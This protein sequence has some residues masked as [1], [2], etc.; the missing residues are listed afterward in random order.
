MALPRRARRSPRSARSRCAAAR[1]SASSRPWSTPT[2]P[3]RRSSPC[4]P[5]S[6][7][8]WS[9]TSPASPR[10]CPAS[11]SSPAAP[12]WWRTTHRSTPAS[13]STTAAS[14]GIPWPRFEVLDTAVLARRTLLRDE[15]PNCRLAT[16]ARVFHATT[17]PNHRALSD[18]RA[19]VDVLH[20][21]FERLGPLGVTSLEEVSTFTARVTPAQ[22]KKRHLAEHLPQ[23]P[24]VY[25]FRDARD[26]VLYVGTSRNLRARVRTYFTESE[27]RT[28]MGEM[29]MLAQRV[30]GI[31][32]ASTLEAAGPRA[33][34]HRPAPPA[35][36]PALQVP[37]PA[38]LAQ[39]HPR[40]V[41]PAVGRQAHP[42]RRRRLHRPVRQPVVRRRR[43]GRPARRVP[44][45]PVHHQ[46]RQAV[47]RV[48][49]AP[50]PS[51]AT[52]SRRATARSSRTP[53]RPRCTACS[54][55]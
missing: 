37:R 42:R 26:D 12:S 40:A 6:P 10:C 27:T 31:V 36:Q 55:P 24:G 32:C 23:A 5:A 1:C 7:T 28:R 9:S 51:W 39:A 45:P 54:A 16:L 47:P 43:H 19:T 3:S 22:R 50:S 21:L 17:T 44:H 46:A 25:L 30:E 13:S 18:A 14:S 29:V 34:P 20:G 11:W 33:P 49:P 53:T 48:R 8:P 35:V 15:V 41:A 52:A 4:S 2:R 38:V